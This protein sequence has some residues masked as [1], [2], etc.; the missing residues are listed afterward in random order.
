MTAWSALF[1]VDPVSRYFGSTQAASKVLLHL[2]FLLVACGLRQSHSHQY[3]IT[4]AGVERGSSR[5]IVHGN[6]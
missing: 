1:S 6:Q 3:N 4:V 5:V 2:L